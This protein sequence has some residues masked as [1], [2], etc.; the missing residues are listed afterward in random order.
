MKTNSKTVLRSLLQLLALF[1]RNDWMSKYTSEEPPLR[2]E[3]LNA[4]QMEQQGKNLAGTHQLITGSPPDQL[5]A[6]LPSH[7]RRGQYVPCPA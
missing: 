6:R 2:S 4:D 5:L 7:R 3:L 1:R